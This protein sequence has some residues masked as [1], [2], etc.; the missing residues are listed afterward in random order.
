M[1]CNIFTCIRAPID[2]SDPLV[3]DSV[4]GSGTINIINT[5]IIGRLFTR[6]TGLIYQITTVFRSLDKRTFIDVR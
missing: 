2:S 4:R 5:V 1:Y 3:A 6:D